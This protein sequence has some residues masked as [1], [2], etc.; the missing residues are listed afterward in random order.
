M[1]GER[2]REHNAQCWLVNTGWQGGGYGVGKR[3]SLPYTRAMVNALVEG[4][5]AA[6]EFEIETAF[7]L[8]IPKAVPGVPAGLLNPRNSW[9]DKAAY[10]KQAADLSERFAKNFEQFDAPREIKEAGPRPVAAK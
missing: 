10:D 3:M 9:A 5:L 4:E 1:L 6:A 8:S 7:G 2:L